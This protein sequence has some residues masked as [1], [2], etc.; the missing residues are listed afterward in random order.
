[1]EYVRAQK[2]SVYVRPSTAIDEVTEEES[3]DVLLDS[4]WRMSQLL[5]EV[6]GEAVVVGEGVLEVLV[7]FALLA[8]TVDA[9]AELRFCFL[10]WRCLFFWALVSLAQSLGLEGLPGYMTILG[11]M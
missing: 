7:V 3:L 5:T 8:E 4:S 10:N 6:L 2:E 9:G 11:L 1:M